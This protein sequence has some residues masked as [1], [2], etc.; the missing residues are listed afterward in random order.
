MHAGLDPNMAEVG[1][2]RPHE[3]CRHAV[4]IDKVVDG[5]ARGE[6]RD[7]KPIANEVLEF[8]R[9]RLEFDAGKVMDLVDRE[10]QSGRPIVGGAEHRGD[11]I[12]YRTRSARTGTVLPI[13]GQY[14]WR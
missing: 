7:P 11:R 14:R 2:P 6:Q 13:A 3:E 5:E 8:V 4:V 1:L 10:Q 9:D 12:A